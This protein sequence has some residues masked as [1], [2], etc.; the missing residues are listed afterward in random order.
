MSEGVIGELENWSWQLAMIV[1]ILIHQINNL[2][3]ASIPRPNEMF[4]HETPKWS[5]L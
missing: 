5:R 1:G 2:P 4:L 3:S